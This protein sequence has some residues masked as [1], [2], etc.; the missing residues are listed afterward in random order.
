MDVRDWDCFLADD[1]DTV[2]VFSAAD[3]HAAGDAFAAQLDEEG[4][5][6]SEGGRIVVSAPTGSDLWVFE[7]TADGTTAL[8]TE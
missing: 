1:P 6:L 8:V 4:W 2:G 7:V 3:P 5:S